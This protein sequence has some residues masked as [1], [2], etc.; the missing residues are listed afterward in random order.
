M[1]KTSEII[2]LTG[3]KFGRLRVLNR[4]DDY[5]SSS[6]DKY[7]R[8][9]C[10]CECGNIKNIFGTCLR[11]GTTKSCGCLKKDLDKHKF[12]THGDSNAHLYYVWRGMRNRCTS[13]ASRIYKYYGARGISVCEEWNKYD[14]FKKWAL[15][16]GYKQGL[17]IDRVDVN[18]NYEPSNCR[19]ITQRE[20][21][22]NRRNNRYIQYN[23]ERKTLTEWVN[24][25]GIEEHVLRYRLN[26]GWNVE[27][28]LNTPVRKYKKG[29]SEQC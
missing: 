24:E 16:N 7:V 11:N 19:W 22:L 13:K 8:W 1:V 27:K 21:N 5:I 23:G 9:V 14:N 28:A 20:Q 4:G 18:G 25:C 3:Q 6:G 12:V 15:S 26:Q 2:D 10:E 29:H 17:S